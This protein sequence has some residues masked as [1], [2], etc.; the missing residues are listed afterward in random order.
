MAKITRKEFFMRASVA[1]AGGYM[2]LRGG[3]TKSGSGDPII[4]LN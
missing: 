3:K 1:A 4:N 2:T